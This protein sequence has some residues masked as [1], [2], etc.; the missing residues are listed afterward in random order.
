MKILDFFSNLKNFGLF[1]NFLKLPTIHSFL[2]L[3]PWTAAL[4]QNYFGMKSTTAESETE[5]FFKEMLTKIIASRKS[6]P[7]NPPDFLQLMLNVQQD[8]K[9]HDLG[10]IAEESKEIE[11]IGKKIRKFFS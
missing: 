6:K 5:E 4:L 8:G 7:K 1:S 9:K 3:F 2:V 11:T 10:T